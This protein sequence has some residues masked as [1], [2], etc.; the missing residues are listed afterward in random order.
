MFTNIVRLRQIFLQAK[1]TAE[2]RGLAIIFIDELDSLAPRRDLVR[3]E[4]EPRLVG[5]LLTLMDGLER[6][7]SKGHTVIIGSTNRREAIDPAL[8]R[9]GRFD[10]E[11]EFD[12]PNAE[13]RKEILKIL[14]NNYVKG[15]Y[16]NINFDEIAEDT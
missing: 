7:E 6:E 4:L 1:E 15:Q 3:G 16:K 2:E 5:Q 10:L 9:P 14:L 8:R 11:I 12:P 13:E